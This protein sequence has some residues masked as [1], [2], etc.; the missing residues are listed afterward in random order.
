MGSKRNTSVTCG[1]I[2]STILLL[3]GIIFTVIW[4]FIDGDKD[5]IPKVIIFWIG[6]GT[7]L[8]AILNFVV[9]ALA[10]TNKLMLG[11]LAVFGGFGLFAGG[12][13]G[14]LDF[15]SFVKARDLVKNGEDAVS[16]KERRKHKKELRRLHKQWMR[17]DPS[18]ARYIHFLHRRKI[19]AVFRS[20]IL[21][22]L[23]IFISLPF[24]AYFLPTMMDYSALFDDAAQ[25]EGLI[26][27]GVFIAY[28]VVCLIFLLINHVQ[29]GFSVD[30]T[31]IKR[32]DIYQWDGSWAINDPMGWK[33]I[34]SQKKTEYSTFY[35]LSWRTLVFFLLGWLMFIPQIIGFFI[36][37]FT[38]YD[39]ENMVCGVRPSLIPPQ[40]QRLS[41]QLSNTVSFFFGFVP[42]NWGYL[43]YLYDL[44][45]SKKRK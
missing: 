45:L 5:P 4:F 32:T 40:Y 8:L 24:L 6:L 28:L 31:R 15:V 26:I 25:A 16:P 33:K 30:Q 35:F 9:V 7:M 21:T 11:L 1:F 34:D 10:P 27:L 42:L 37:L 3:F 38:P 29:I 2:A 12:I 43:D 20:L 18:Y 22:A 36:T 13:I 14:I 19:R 44:S 39:S 17:E 41:F 23:S